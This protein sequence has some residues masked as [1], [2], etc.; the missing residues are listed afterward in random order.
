MSD[1]RQTEGTTRTK[2]MWPEREQPQTDEALE[3]LLRNL[4]WKRAMPSAP[5]SPRYS[6]P[7]YSWKSSVAVQAER[8]PSGGL[9]SWRKRENH[10][11]VDSTPTG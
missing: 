6:W 3:R 9:R 10:E 1:E 8:M 2:A 4:S 7:R 5:T 11:N